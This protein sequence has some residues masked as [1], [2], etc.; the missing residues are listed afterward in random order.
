MEL[1]YQGIEQMS[2]E[3]AKIYNADENDGVDAAVNAG[4]IDGADRN[5]GPAE[6]TRS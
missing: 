2:D 4:W 3:R 5:E 1:I 6:N